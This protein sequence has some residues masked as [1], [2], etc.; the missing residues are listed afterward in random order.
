M[1]RPARIEKPKKP[2]NVSLDVALVEEAKSLGINVSQACENGLS[3]KVR[4]ARESQWLE[5]NR[6]SLL[7]WNDWVSEHGML[8]EEYRQI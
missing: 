3:E 8:Y 4:E 1:N 6:V 7:A 2:T 5:E